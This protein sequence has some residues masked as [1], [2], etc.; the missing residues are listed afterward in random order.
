MGYSQDEKKV[1]GFVKFVDAEKEIV[2]DNINHYVPEKLFVYVG[3][4]MPSNTFY[5]GQ[6]GLVR[7]ALGDGAFKKGNDFVEGDKDHFKYDAGLKDLLG[8]KDAAAPVDP[9]K[10]ADKPLESAHDKKA[11]VVDQE[12]DNLPDL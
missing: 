8:K 12:R 2:Y 10:V 7:V 11:P 3:H 6:I 5:S 1:R 4:D 9:T